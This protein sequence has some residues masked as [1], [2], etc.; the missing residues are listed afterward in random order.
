M[1]GP[2]NITRV[3]TVHLALP[4]AR[5]RV[6]LTDPAP[7][8]TAVV[9]VRVHTDTPHVG[10]GFTTTP[11]GARALQPLLDGDL[12]PLVVGEDPTESDRRFAKAQGRFRAAGGGGLAGV[13]AGGAGAATGGA[14]WA[15]GATACGAG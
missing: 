6:S 5:T 3:E 4:P 1:T 13:P 14:A 7:A 10:L 12:G 8:P 2:M 15:T 9:A 11:A